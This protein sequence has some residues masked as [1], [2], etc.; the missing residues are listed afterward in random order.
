MLGQIKNFSEA[1]ESFNKVIEIDPNDIQA[2]IDMGSMEASRG[3]FQ[4]ALDAF[5]KIIEIDSNL[6]WLS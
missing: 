2:L 1:I 3:N 4:E 5:N 6:N